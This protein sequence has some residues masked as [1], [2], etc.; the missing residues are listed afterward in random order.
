MSHAA[1]LTIHRD[2]L[3]LEK[4]D[5]DA[6]FEAW[7]DHDRWTNPYLISDTQIRG[8]FDSVR[9]AKAWQKSNETLVEAREEDIKV[10]G[11]P[12]VGWPFNNSF[13]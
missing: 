6:A 10:K 9:K 5:F 1:D 8:P 13:V 12:I 2:S 11:L 3:E 7:D 4:I